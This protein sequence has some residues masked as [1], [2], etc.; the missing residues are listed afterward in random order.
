MGTVG[1]N[2]QVF[3][4]K[5]LGGRTTVDKTQQVS[6]NPAVY[7]SGALMITSAAIQNYFPDL[8]ETWEM[9]QAILPADQQW[10]T[11]FGVPVSCWSKTAFDDKTAQ[12]CFAQVKGHLKVRADAF[13]GQ[14]TANMRQLWP[15]TGAY[16]NEGDYFE[17]DWQQQFYGKSYGK[18]KEVKNVVDP[19]GLFYCHHCVGSEE[20]SADGNCRVD[21]PA[22]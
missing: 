18:L 2:V 11:T 7:D 15:D 9:L 16:L 19:H 12:G 1:A 20:W 21:P 17:G 14:H 10:L 6:M 4:G 3:L 8:P 13:N 5:A 22:W